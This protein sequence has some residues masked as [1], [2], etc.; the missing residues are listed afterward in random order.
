M[1]ESLQR[2]ADG[3]FRRQEFAVT[4]WY[5]SAVLIKMQVLSGNNLQKF[6]FSADFYYKYAFKLREMMI[7]RAK[8]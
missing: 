8:L 4:S 5:Y 7:Q 3:S 1:V 6:S 2:I